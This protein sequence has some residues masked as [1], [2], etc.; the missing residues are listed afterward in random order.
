MKRLLIIPLLFIFAICE[1]QTIINASP[2]LRVIAAE[3]GGYCDEYQ[4]VYDAM[5]NK[6]TTYVEDQNTLVEELKTAG[7]WAKRDLIYVFAQQT[8]DDGEALLN[9]ANPGTFTCTNVSATLFTALEGFTGDGSADYLNTNWNVSSDKDN[10]ALDDATIAIYC[11]VSDINAEQYAIGAVDGS[12]YVASI[13]PRYAGEF[14]I[15]VNGPGSSKAVDGS[16]GLFVGVRTNSTTHTYYRNG[17]S[18]GTTANNST[19]LPNTDL[20]ILKWTDGGYTTNQVSFVF[21]GGALTDTE[22]ADMFT[23]V[24]KYMDA[25]SKGV[26]TP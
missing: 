3:E 25:M 4:A 20:L 10:Y 12:N 18:L 7:V 8:N 22:V 19:G 13:K 26:V 21:V 1:S 2:P 11:R 9:W 6:P 16:D 14:W 24:E 17:S 23:A 5:T 15:D